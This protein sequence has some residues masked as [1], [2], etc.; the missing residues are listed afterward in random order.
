M[1]PHLIANCARSIARGYQAVPR[2][3]ESDEAGDVSWNAGWASGIAANRRRNDGR[4]EDRVGQQVAVSNFGL[5]GFVCRGNWSRMVGWVSMV[6]VFSI[7]C[8]WEGVV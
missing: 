4:P 8:C 5:R 1:F 2:A 6:R 3:E 7:M